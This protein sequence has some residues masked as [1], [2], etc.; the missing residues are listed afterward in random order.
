MLKV[1]FASVAKFQLPGDFARSAVRL[2]TS[3]EITRIR[4]RWWFKFPQGHHSVPRRD[5]ANGLVTASHLGG[6]ET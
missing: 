6:N 1:D 4:S 5:P 3:P 2:D